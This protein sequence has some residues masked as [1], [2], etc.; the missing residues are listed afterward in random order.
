MPSFCFACEE[1]EQAI[2]LAAPRSELLWLRDR[3][4][5]VREVGRHVQAGLDTWMTEG[6]EFLDAHAGHS[7][8]INRRP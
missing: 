3:E 8:V 7:V 1:C 6:L 2:W 4:H 5:G